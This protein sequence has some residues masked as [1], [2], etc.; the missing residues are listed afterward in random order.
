M[1]FVSCVLPSYKKCTGYNAGSTH[2]ITRL[3]LWQFNHVMHEQHSIRAV[4]SRCRLQTRAPDTGHYHR[5][6]KG[7]P[8]FTSKQSLT[9]W[10]VLTLRGVYNSPTMRHDVHNSPGMRHDLY[11]SPGMR[12]D[13]HNSPGM[14]RAAAELSHHSSWPGECPCVTEPACDPCYQRQTPTPSDAAFSVYLHMTRTLTQQCW[15]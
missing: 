2:T 14:R 13:V 6:T 3:Q 11:N 15:D 10:T 12:H 8:A 5:T 4:F 9:R 1:K 7:L